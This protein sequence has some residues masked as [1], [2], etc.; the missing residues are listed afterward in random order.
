M[1][2]LDMRPLLLLALLALA[3]TAHAQ[4]CEPARATSALEQAGVRA[5]LFNNGAL[6]W[7]D[8]ASPRGY[9]VPRG[10]GI[11]SV[12]HASL[13]IAGRVN[14]QDRF[15]GSR[16]GPYEYWPG[17]LDADG[18]TDADRCAAYDR[19]WRVTLE[20]IARYNTTGEA[21]AD[22]AEWP[23]EAG[24]PVV[25]GSGDP[26]D[27]DL[28]AGDRPAILGDE[29]A[30][31]IMNDRGDTHDWSELAAIGIEVRVTAFTISESYATR[32][33]FSRADARSLHHATVYRYTLTYRGDEPLDNAYLGWFADTEIGYFNDDFVGSEPEQGMAYTYNADVED[34]AAWRTNNP[35]YGTQPPALGVRFLSGPAEK[36]LGCFMWNTFLSSNPSGTNPGPDA[37]GYLQCLWRHGSPVTFG[38]NGFISGPETDY[39][40][41]GRPPEYWSELN[42]DGLG[43]PNTPGDRWLIQSHGP[44]ALAP[45]QT[46]EITVALPW[47]R[48]ERG[49]LGSVRELIA[50]A[51][52]L[53]AAAVSDLEPDPDLSTITL[54]QLPVPLPAAPV[55]PETPA[56]DAV[57]A[58]VQPNPTTGDTVL[59]LDLARHAHVRL[60][61]FDALGR[62]VSVP[63]DGTLGPAIHR[64]AISTEGWPPG[65]YVYRLGVTPEQQSPIYAT[66]RFTVSR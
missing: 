47:A 43:T 32:L 53:L 38:N 65:V 27:Y 35:T 40:F 31:W 51:S 21:T 18:Q 16:Y 54:G 23:A 58:S 66:G 22:L 44:F 61:V 46:V 60:T 39:M 59:R 1:T 9:E 49:H 33:G 14:G 52:P 17:P 10:A 20:D 30:W 3:S 6:F 19:I 57:S 29:T 63:V 37:Y 36:R 24:A 34:G 48:S 2:P 15:A 7:R 56:T 12:F 42:I 45:E 11:H 13:W 4:T 26:D 8:D 50:H 25:D 5:Q 28:A 64:L 55:P 62:E 41:P